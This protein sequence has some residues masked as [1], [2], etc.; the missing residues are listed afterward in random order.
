MDL[1]ISGKTAIVAAASKGLGKA[2]ALGL[3]KEGA[4]LAICARGETALLET[5]EE[6][7][8]ATSATVLSIAADVTDADDIQKL[9]KSTADEFGQ[10]DI[11]VTNAGGP[12]S[13]LFSDFSDEDWQDAM[14]LNLLST[15]R[16]CREVI[17]HMQKGSGG[18]IVNI[19]SIAAKQPVEGLILSNS[20]RAAV[21]GLA[22]TLSNELAGDNILVNSVCPGW[23][24]T[25]RLSSIVNNRAQSQGTS[26]ESALGNITAN[27][28]LGRCGT[29]EEVTSL[30]VFLASERASY[31][32]GATIQVDGGLLKSLF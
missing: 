16:L 26:Y 13:G 6:I 14:T 5:A 30:I 7:R 9:V 12:P 21:I 17:P 23:I 27:I 32:T 18:R 25:D 22:K 11:L 28:P 3:A 1:G 31:L 8:S 4:N 19:V 10:I 20:L 29:P 15:I 2:V 24:L